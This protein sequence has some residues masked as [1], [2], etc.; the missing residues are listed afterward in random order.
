VT[1]QR[2][3]ETFISTI[4]HLD[5]RIDLYRDENLLEQLDNSVSA[6]K[7]ATKEIGNRALM[8][9]CIMASK[10]AYEN[11]KVVQSTVVQHWKASDSNFCCPPQFFFSCLF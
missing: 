5:G 6:E 8:D 2:D 9:L 7:I 3:T 10:L 11:A 1:P 4:G